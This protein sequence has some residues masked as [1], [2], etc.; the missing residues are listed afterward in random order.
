MK[1]LAV[2]VLGD[3]GVDGLAP[4]ALGSRKA[5]QVLHLLALG[6][7]RTPCSA[8]TVDGICATR[9]PGAAHVSKHPTPATV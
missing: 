6:Q 2:R 4:H 7:S 8:R 3:F 9:A 5:R 1:S